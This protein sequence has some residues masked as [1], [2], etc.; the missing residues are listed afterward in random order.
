MSLKSLIKTAG[1]STA[2][3][4]T[5]SVL[6]GE[7]GLG[8]TTIA[9]LCFP[10]PLFIPIEADGIRSLPDDV[11][12]LPRA[13]GFGHGHSIPVRHLRR[14][15]GWHLRVRHGGV[16]QR[17]PPRHHDRRGSPRDPWRHQ[18][19]RCRRI[20]QGLLRGHRHHG[21]GQG[22]VQRHRGIRHPHRGVRPCRICQCRSARQGAVQPLHPATRQGLHE[23]LAESGQR[24]HPCP[25]VGYAEQGQEDGEH[26]HDHRARICGSST[27]C[28][29]P[30]TRPKTASGSVRRSCSNITPMPVI[31]PTPS[32][33]ST[34]SP[35]ARRQ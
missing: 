35:P 1:E 23:V 12:V 28:R 13:T 11:A 19:R 3:K 33:R 4:G 6:Y 7:A 5:I 27:W 30:A 21:G 14:G 8:K 9:A 22:V 31:S 26:N 34:G 15:A 10:K 32:N 25:R 2:G 18:P 24:V 29:R 16:G 20:R 17:V